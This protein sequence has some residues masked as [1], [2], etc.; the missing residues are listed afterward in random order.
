M[1]ARIRSPPNSDTLYEGWL[2]NT[3]ETF[4]IRRLTTIGTAILLLW[5]IAEPATA[6]DEKL[7]KQQFEG[8]RVTLRMDM[9][10]S[11]E[12]VDVLVDTTKTINFSR[13]RNDLKR[14]GTALRA[15]DS[16]LVTL[17]RVKKDIIEFQLDGGG[18]GTWS[19]DTSTSAN[20]Q[21]VPESSRE[22]ELERSIKSET[23]KGRKS[24]MQSELNRLRNDRERE[25]RWRRA[26]IARIEEAKRIRI[27]EQ[28][29]RG[30]SRFNLRYKDRVPS[31]VQPEDVMAALVEY[32]DFQPRERTD[33]GRGQLSRPADLTQLR[34][35]LT[36][37]ET[38]QLLG[39]PVSTSEKRDGNLTV[40]TLVFESDDQRVTAEFVEDLLVRYTISSK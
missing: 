12:G 1:R 13:Y 17:I 34:K 7:L 37:D 33:N 26:E 21:L 28:R 11:S 3:S 10:G 31:N 5:S 4:M 8:R 40:A 27:A 38:E 6:Q 25:N 19:D 30:G 29:L 22:K 24:S 18:F 36:R 2:I 9:P 20:I 39:R 32:V 23:D 16:A 35:G 14:Y 15:D